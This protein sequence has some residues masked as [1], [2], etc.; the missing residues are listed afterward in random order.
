M[1]MSDRVLRSMVAGALLSLVVAAP[2]LAVKPVGG[3]PNSQY[4]VMTLQGFIDLEV[5]VG[6][7]TDVVE[8]LPGLLD[9]I[10]ANNDG[11]V[12][13]LDVPDTRGHQGPVLFNIVDNTSHSN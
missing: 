9:V 7:P 4:D 10:D 8:G 1:S 11:H 12:C 2:A 13:I 5:S 3:C 6:A